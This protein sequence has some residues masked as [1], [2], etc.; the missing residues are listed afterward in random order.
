MRNTP[1]LHC[2]YLRGSKE[3]FRCT[4]IGTL[5]PDDIA[6]GWNP[7]NLP[8]CPYFLERQD[9][10]KIDLESGLLVVAKPLRRARRK[11]DYTAPIRLNPDVGDTKREIME[12]ISRFHVERSKAWP[13]KT[14]IFHISRFRSL[15]YIDK[16]L[17]IMVREGQLERTS[18]TSS[19]RYSVAY[20]IPKLT[21]N[22]I[23]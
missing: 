5:L 23:P 19:R 4:S 10:D 21:Q 12:I 2:V 17:D 16:L 22:S 9:A 6:L 14:Q 7:D 11:R 1:C 13:S 8:D 15:S 18:D 20:M 3:N